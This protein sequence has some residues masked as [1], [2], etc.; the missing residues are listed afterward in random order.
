MLKKWFL[1]IL[2]AGAIISG[3][4]LFRNS[5]TSEPIQ[6]NSRTNVEDILWNPHKYNGSVV[7]LK[8]EVKF[9]GANTALKYSLEDGTGQII[10]VAPRSIP[11]GKDVS[12]R[13]IVRYYEYDNPFV[14]VG[15]PFVEVL[16]A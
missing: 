4:Y 15:R 11:L 3:F 8:G 6:S 13:G 5:E 7:L 16:I 2:L 14:G 9:L 1:I 12:V 10:L